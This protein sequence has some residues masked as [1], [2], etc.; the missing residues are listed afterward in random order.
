MSIC[1]RRG[2]AGD[3]SVVSEEGHLYV[4][5]ESWRYGVGFDCKVEREAIKSQ[6]I[7]DRLK[8][9]L[10]SLSYYEID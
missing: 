7:Y 8:E 6:P 1:C 10:S 9:K 5:C 2:Q 4:V 3:I